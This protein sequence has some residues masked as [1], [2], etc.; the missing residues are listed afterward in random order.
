MLS[1][2][3]GSNGCSD[4]APGAQYWFASGAS[5]S[6][7]RSR[8]VGACDRGGRA[9]P[10]DGACDRARFDDDSD[11]D[12]CGRACFELARGPDGD[13][14]AQ[15]EARRCDEHVTPLMLLLR[16]PLACDVR[17]RCQRRA[18]WGTCVREVARWQLRS[19]AHSC[20]GSSGVRCDRG[21]AHNNGARNSTC[22]L[23]DRTL[24]VGPQEGAGPAEQPRRPSRAC[25]RC[26]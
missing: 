9:C 10:P 23:G 7:I 17:T 19:H 15:R 4:A 26:V 24:T 22:S 14:M 20:S 1:M 12:C 18:A 13:D 21:G 8:T 11:D 5:S 3:D 6:V 2:I 25:R 16:S